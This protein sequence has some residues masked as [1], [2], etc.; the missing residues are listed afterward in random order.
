MSPFVLPESILEGA[1]NDQLTRRAGQ[2]R[3]GGASE[4]R[5]LRELQEV[6]GRRCRPPLEDKEV[7]VIAHSVARYPP[8]GPRITWG[9]PPRDLVEVARRRG[10]RLVDR[11]HPAPL[12]LSRFVVG[13]RRGGREF[14]VNLGPT[15]GSPRGPSCTCPW[16]ASPANRTETCAHLE[17]VRAWVRLRY[18]PLEVAPGPV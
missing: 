18:A 5:I 3:R 2:L 6:N 8:A 13:A 15:P 16:F 17:A 7:R 11:V 1:R 9:H 14:R 12:H 4:D 10:S